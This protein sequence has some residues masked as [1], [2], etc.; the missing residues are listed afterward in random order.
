MYRIYE[1]IYVRVLSVTYE[2][3]LINAWF[4]EPR[5]SAEW[6][7]SQCYNTREFLFLVQRDD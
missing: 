2:S 6:K 5:I 3:R 4:R 7:M 1:H